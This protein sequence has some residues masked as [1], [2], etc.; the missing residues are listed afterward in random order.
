MNM[1]MSM[2]T[3]KNHNNTG[4]TNPNWK[5]AHR[6]REYKT[7]LE[8]NLLRISNLDLKINDNQSDYNTIID[9]H[10]YEI[11]EAILSAAQVAKITSKKLYKPKKYWCPKLSCLKDHKRFWWCLWI[12]NGHSKSGA[13]H[14]CYKKC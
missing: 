5:T 13:V 3:R 10:I 11:N 9:N 2:N 12:N 4:F 1:N 8:T 6:N 7:I 14:D